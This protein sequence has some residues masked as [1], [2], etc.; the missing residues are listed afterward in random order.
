MVGILV[1]FVLGGELEVDDYVGQDDDEF[2]DYCGLVLFVDGVGKFVQ[3]YVFFW[4]FFV[5][6]VV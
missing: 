2:D 3:D 5:G 4:C 1:G 6:C